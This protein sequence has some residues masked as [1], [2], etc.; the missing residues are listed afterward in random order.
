MDKHVAKLSKRYKI[1][2]GQAE[3]LVEA[4]FKTPKD[5]I[6]ARKQDLEAVEGVGAAA[7]KK[8]R[9]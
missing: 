9:R 7:V 4:G 6:K 3:K 8:L 5:I 2:L 1:K